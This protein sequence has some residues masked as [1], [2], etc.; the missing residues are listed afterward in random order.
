MSAKFSRTPSDE[1]RLLTKPGLSVIRP[2][3]SSYHSNDLMRRAADLSQGYAPVL[4]KCGID[5]HLFMAFHKTAF[6]A[7]QVGC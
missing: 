3:L 1:I 2:I 4:A 6:K 5:Q 7:S